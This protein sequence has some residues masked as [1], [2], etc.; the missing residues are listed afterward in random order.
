V[1]AV[2]FLIGKPRASNQDTDG[3]L[4]QQ[5][6]DHLEKVVT[7]HLARLI[8]D[9]DCGYPDYESMWQHMAAVAPQWS[10]LLRKALWRRSWSPSPKCILKA[11]ISR[12]QFI[13]Y[14]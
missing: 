9:P 11:R 2:V 12:W 10:I 5:I 3:I 13:L 1:P 6:K 4:F 7:E 8:P 14:I